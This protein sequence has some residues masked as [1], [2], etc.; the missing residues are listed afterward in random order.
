MSEDR[1]NH[2]NWCQQEQ[3]TKWTPA[4]Q[5]VANP[6]GGQFPRVCGKGTPRSTP[7]TQKQKPEPNRKRDDVRKNE[8]S[9]YEGK[10]RMR[11]YRKKGKG[12]RKGTRFLDWLK[13]KE[14]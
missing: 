8:R 1:W 4:T 9:S 2:T 12:E 11:H 10:R 7:S 3:S 14:K 6:G 13:G 5:R